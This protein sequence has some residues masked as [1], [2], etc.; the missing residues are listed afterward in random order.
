MTQDM[1]TLQMLQIMEDLWQENGLDL[2]LLPYGCVSTGKLTALY[3]LIFVF[4]TII[5]AFK[6]V[7]YY[8]RSMKL[9]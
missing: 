2:Y 9:K 8:C 1:V 5:G 3:Q 4:Y 7:I 6:I